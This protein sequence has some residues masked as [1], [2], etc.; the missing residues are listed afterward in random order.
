MTQEVPENWSIKSLG[1]VIDIK[2]G[3]QP[4][5]SQFVY[6]PQDGYIQLLQI[7]DFGKKPVPTYVPQ[8]KVTKFCEKDD[9]LIAR[10]GASLGR[11]VTGHAGAYNVA[12]AKVIPWPG[13]FINRYL[14]YLLQTSVLQTPLKMISRSAQNGFA[15]HEVAHVQLPIPPLN[16]QHRIV[17]K[18]EELFSELDKGIESLKTAREQLKVYRQALLKHA[19]EGKLTEHLPS[20]QAGWRD[21]EFRNISGK[22]VPKDSQSYFAYVLVCKG[23]KLYKGFSS[24][25][26]ERI[27]QHLA[28]QGAKFT[29]EHHPVSLLHFEMFDTEQEAVKRE[30]YFKSGSGREWLYQLRGQQEEKHPTATEL[31]ERIKQEREA[32]YQ[33]QLEDW[34]AAMSADR[35]AVKQWPARRPP[36]ERTG[37]GGEADLPC[38]QAGGK[39][40]KKPSKPRKLKLPDPIDEE[41]LSNLP[42]LPDGWIWVKLGTLTWSVKDGPHYSPKYK[43]TGIPFISGGNIRPSGVDFENVKYIS[44]E[45]HLE[46]CKRCKPAVGDILY[47]KGGTTGIAR[48]NTYEHEFN[49]WVHVAVLKLVDSIKP[50]FLQHVLNSPFPYSQ[51]QKY[52]HG[53]GNQDLGLTRM[54]NIILP[55]CSEQEQEQIIEEVDRSASVLDGLEEEIRI[56]LE[57]SEALRQSILKKAF[58]GQLVAQDSKDEPA[59]V[60]LER[61]AAEKAQAV[62]NNKKRKVSGKKVR[63]KPSPVKVLPFKTRFKGISTTDL[64]AGILALAQ[65]HYQDSE[66]AL[67]NFGHIK[68]EK[69]VHLVEAHLGIDLARNPVKAA[70]GPNDY[71]HLMKVESRARKAGFFDVRRTRFRY[72]L[73]KGRQFDGLV[74]KTKRVLGSRLTDVESLLELMKPL[75][76][77]QAEVA[78]TLYAAW[79]NLLLDGQQPDDE[80]IV[81]EARENWHKGKL[82]IKRDRFFR[83]LQWMRDNGLIPLGKGEKVVRKGRRQ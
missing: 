2:G 19:F 31:L 22:L 63:H 51:S 62:A 28:G 20:R 6:E 79:N 36:V 54:V 30:K 32:R 41:E 29:K 39:E 10:Y 47:T 78:A 57:K 23:G 11:I 49:V 13:L 24:N 55:V 70:A 61:I 74:D 60:L 52:T 17:A 7:R 46:L 42:L 37:V 4:P 9:V 83:G 75:D 44:E 25:L 33:Q 65:S 76:T 81:T 71:P 82:K 50:F 64:H 34:K 80:A 69:I 18:I 53:V 5:K 35:Q 59:S 48:V 58:S 26:F 15:K 77:R 72:A 3:S 14:F 40:G 43:E 8:E 73:N 45:L 66:E 12:L 16:E 68:G 27:D 21:P 38:R 1:E 56:A 67:Q